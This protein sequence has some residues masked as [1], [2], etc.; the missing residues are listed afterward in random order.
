MHIV[1]SK[2]F[3][4][5]VLSIVYTFFTDT[6]FFKIDSK[7]QNFFDSKLCNLG[8]QSLSNVFYYWSLHLFFD[9]YCNQA[10]DYLYIELEFWNHNAL[11]S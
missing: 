11:Y 4:C 6:K 8:S 5:E 1:K 3:F 10:Q 7:A 9:L 2:Y